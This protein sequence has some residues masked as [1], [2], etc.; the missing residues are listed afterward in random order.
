[1]LL[2]IGKISTIWPTCAIVAAFA[3]TN[4]KLITAAMMANPII[5]VAT[6]VACIRYVAIYSYTQ[7]QKDALAEVNTIEEV[8]TALAEKRK[9]FLEESAKLADGYGGKTRENVES[10]TRR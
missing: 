6:A 1:M 4:W 5:A 8:E 7:A 9:K 2:F 3:T 10:I